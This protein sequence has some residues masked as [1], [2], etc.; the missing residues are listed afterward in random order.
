MKNLNFIVLVVAILFPLHSYAA[1]EDKTPSKEQVKEKQSQK[2]LV[3]YV[4]PKPIRP[5]PKIRTSQG[6]TRGCGEFPVV[7]L[8]APEH[9]ALTMQEQPQLY[10]NISAMSQQ[11]AVVTLSHD[12]AVEPLFEWHVPEPIES[13]IHTI[14]IAEH[15]IYLEVGQT[16]EWSVR[17]A[18]E[19]DESGSGDLVVKS[20]IERVPVDERIE[21]IEQLGDPIVLANAY[22][23]SGIWHDAFATLHDAWS[24]DSDNQILKSAWSGMLEEMDLIEP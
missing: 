10:W 17:M 16:Y 11:S 7:T 3:P 8:L 23:G 18:C 13:G 24:K 5:T 12:E 19:Q 1:D 9:V 14:D 6:G 22:A 15:D 21:S 2:P 20:Y 4:P